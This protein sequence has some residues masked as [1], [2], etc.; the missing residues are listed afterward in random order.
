M[1]K[2]NHN[3]NNPDS[4]VP[5]SRFEDFKLY[6]AELRSATTA[7]ILRGARVLTGV[8]GIPLTVVAAFTALP[9]LIIGPVTFGAMWLE[10]KGIKHF[11]QKAQVARS[12]RRGQ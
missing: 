8:V 11:E 5:G 9:A 2:N 12:L 10:T 1:I 4:Q 6:S 3:M 7:N